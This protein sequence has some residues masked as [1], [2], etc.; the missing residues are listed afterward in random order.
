MIHCYSSD[1]RAGKQDR[2]LTGSRKRK[3]ILHWSVQCVLGKQFTPL[4]ACVLVGEGFHIWLDSSER[5]SQ[6]W[7]LPLKWESITPLLLAGLLAWLFS[8]AQLV[9]AGQTPLTWPFADTV[10]VQM[11]LLL[12]IPKHLFRNKNFYCICFLWV[13]SFSNIQKNLLVCVFVNK[14]FWCVSKN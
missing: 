7:H 3:I 11:S 12:S 8:H 10:F 4:A 13:D 5:S 6:R 9:S 1:T 2:S 14:L